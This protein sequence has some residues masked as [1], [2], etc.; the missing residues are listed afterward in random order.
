MALAMLTAADVMTTEPIAVAEHESLAMAWE[1]LARGHVGF[2]PVVRHGRVVGVLDDRAV[3]QSRTPRWLD[4]QPR[5]V[6][7][8]ARTATT[9]HPSTSL[10][11]LLECFTSTGDTAVVVVDDDGGAVGLV[12]AA[13]VLG[14]FE[15]AL[16]S[17]HGPHAVEHE[18]S[19]LRRTA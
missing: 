16:G 19:R 7:D 13:T 18:P 10:P 11:T 12:L 5:L 17:H 15:R 2:V 9:V 14:L 6:A 3:V 1:V 4:G 8:A